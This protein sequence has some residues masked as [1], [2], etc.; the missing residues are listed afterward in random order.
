M[1][2]YQIIE[3]N[4]TMSGKH[5]IRVVIDADTST[6]L[7]YVDA[8]SD[9]EIQRDAE[10]FDLQ[11]K[12]AALRDTPLPE[13]QPEPVT[14]KL[15]KLAYMGRFTDAELEA[16]YAAAK[17][18]PAVEVWLEKFRLAEDID[19]SDPRLLAGLQALEA[20]GILAVGR[21]TEILG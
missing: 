17:V 19:T 9:A 15:T 3:R 4:I 2:M 11:R 14:T 8:P 7:H 18:S 21:A 5:Q 13:V 16:L 1:T 20:A 10:A 6:F 12:L